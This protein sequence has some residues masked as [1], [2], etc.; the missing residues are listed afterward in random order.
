M[1]VISI[2]IDDD[3][4]DTLMHYCSDRCMVTT[5]IVLII[6]GIDLIIEPVDMTHWYQIVID[7]VCYYHCYRDLIGIDID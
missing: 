2:V 4:D 1:I 5:I 7:C 6:L 3:D